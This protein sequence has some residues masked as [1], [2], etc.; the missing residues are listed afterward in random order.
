MALADKRMTL[1]ARLMQHPRPDDTV[2]DIRLRAKAL[3]AWC[4]ACHDADVMQHRRFLKKFLVKPQLW[5]CMGY[6]QTTICHLP[7]VRQ[8]N[9][10][11]LIL[12][13]IMQVYHLLPIHHNAVPL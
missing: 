12:L 10:A 13:R 9:P 4:I 5:V 1:I 8:Q 2:A 3:N 11:Q 6:L 7:T